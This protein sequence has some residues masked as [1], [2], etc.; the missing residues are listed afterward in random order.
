MSSLVTGVAILL[1]GGLFN[2]HPPAPPTTIKVQFFNDNVAQQLQLQNAQQDWNAT[3]QM[4]LQQQ[5]QMQEDFQR[6]LQQT[7]QQLR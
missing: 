1:F 4:Q 5:R 3:L 6:T 7:Q 2:H